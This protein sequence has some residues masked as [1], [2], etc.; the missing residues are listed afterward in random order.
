VI[1]DAISSATA[2]LNSIAGLLG[3]ITGLSLV[4]SPFIAKRRKG[5]KT[6]ADSATQSKA[7]AKEVSA[8]PGEQTDST[9]PA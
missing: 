5:N 4:A 2:G 8:D 3:A 1:S 7:P 6:D 9:S